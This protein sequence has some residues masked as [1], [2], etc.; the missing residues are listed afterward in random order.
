[1]AVDKCLWS[2]FLSVVVAAVLAAP[3]AS[4]QTFTVLHTFSYATDGSQPAGG[5]ISDSAGNL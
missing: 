1:M 4:A 5:L 2:L 3:V